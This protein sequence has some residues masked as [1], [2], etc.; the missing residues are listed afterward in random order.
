LRLPNALGALPIPT[1]VCDSST[2]TPGIGLAGVAFRS[3]ASVRGWAPSAA[4]ISQIVTRRP[5][6]ACRQREGQRPV[7]RGAE[8]DKLFSF[9]TL[10]GRSGLRKAVSHVT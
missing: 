7:A 4:P 1:Q 3:A 6:G 10:F 2:A 9:A 8:T 5:M